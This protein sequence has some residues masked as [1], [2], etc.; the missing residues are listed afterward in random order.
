[1]EPERFLEHRP[2]PPEVAEQFLEILLLEA[3]V[4]QLPE[5]GSHPLKIDFRVC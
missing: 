3:L 4:E 2:R 5:V 1:L